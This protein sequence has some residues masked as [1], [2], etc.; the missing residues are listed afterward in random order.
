MSNADKNL[1][2][3]DKAIIFATNAHS[4]MK[5]KSTNIP[6]ILHPLEAAAIVASITDDENII[7]AAVLHDVLE[8]TPVTLEELER[9]FGDIARLVAAETEDKRVGQAAKDTWK[10]RKQEA[11]EHLRDKATVEMKIITLG[12]KLSNIRAISR[13][14]AEIGDKVWERFNQK[15]KAEHA[16]YYKSICDALSELKDY[17]AWR[18]YEKLINKVFG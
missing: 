8:D 17:A 5:R 12:D 2:V 14:Y 7:S 13:D 4:G 3:V 16:W 9:E 18:E 11:V 6:Y 10:I 15:D 1:S